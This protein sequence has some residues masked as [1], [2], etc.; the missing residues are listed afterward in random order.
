MI[1]AELDESLGFNIYRTGLLFRRELMRALSRYG[2]TPEQWQ[3]LIA[4]REA[5][6]PVTQKH[7]THTVLKD[8]YT[9]SRILSRMDRDGWIDKSADDRDARAAS[10]ALSARGKRMVNQ[11]SATVNRHFDCLL[12]DFPQKSCRTVISDLKR[13]RTLLGDDAG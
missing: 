5:G 4:L 7:I 10:V 1:P 9:L 6:A 12:R 11:V 2:L 13:L 3:I 8:K